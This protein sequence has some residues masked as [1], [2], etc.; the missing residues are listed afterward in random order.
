MGFFKSLMSVI[1]TD[2]KTGT[3]FNFDANHTVYFK[4]DGVTKI[5]AARVAGYLKGYGL[6]TETNQ[7]D[8]QIFSA[9]A[10]QPVEVSFVIPRKTTTEEA[11]GVYRDTA[12]GLQE[13]LDG[14]KVSVHLMGT[15]M[16]RLKDL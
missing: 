9:K 8:V 7:S 14:R 6:F 11:E 12:E 16:V 4:G 1:S 2:G 10:G 5:D 13:L 15:D 3:P